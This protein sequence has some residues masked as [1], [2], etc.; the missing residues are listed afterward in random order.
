MVFPPVRHAKDLQRSLGGNRLLLMFFA[1]SHNLYGGFYS[2]DRCSLWK[3]DNPA[4]LEKRTAA[5]LRSLGNFDANHELQ[6]SQLTDDSW[7]QA[8]K[9]VLTATLSNPKT[10]FNVEFKELII[11]PDGVLWYV[12]FEILPMGDPKENR[13]LISRMRVRYAPTVGLAFSERE[14]RKALPDLGI[15]AGK[16]FPSQPAEFAQSAADAIQHT[17][18]HSVALRTPLPAISPLLGSVLDGIVALDDIPAVGGPYDWPPIPL[19]KNKNIGS[20]SA[21]LGLPWKSSD[22]FIFPSF[23]TAAENSLKTVGA[24]PGNDLFL[25]TTGLMATGARTILISRWRTGG[26]TA[27]DLVRQ[28]IQEFPFSTAD[29]AWQRAVQLV[30][31]SPLDPQHEPRVK[32]KPDAPPVNAENPFF[33]AG[34]L[35]IDTG[36]EPQSAMEKP[37]DK[38]PTLKLDDKKKPPDTKPAQNN[39]DDK[40]SEEPKSDDQNPADRKSDEKTTKSPDR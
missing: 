24:V 33:W 23:H 3:I 25:A 30:S 6:E 21:W 22:V 8:A 11:V 1:T 17:A 40:K 39:A 2:T 18:A 29:E 15:I 14:G 28:F 31:Q 7:R 38:P 20:L 13:P 10:A 19:E 34:Y 5:L 4:L 32:C 36:A 37:Q 27:V 12:P 9:D 26:Q 35:L 16:L